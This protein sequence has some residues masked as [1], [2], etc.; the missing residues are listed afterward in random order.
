M[1]LEETYK[2]FVRNGALLND[3]KEQLKK[4]QY[5]ALKI[6]AILDKMF[7]QRPINIIKHLTNKEDLAGIPEAIL[8]AIWRRRKERNLEGYVIT[9]QFPSLLPILTYAKRELRKELAIGNGKIFDGGEFDNQN[10][11]KELVKLRQE[12]SQ[13]LGYKSLVDYVLEERM[14][15][16]PQKVL[17]FEQNYW[18]KQNLCRKDGKNFPF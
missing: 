2:G 18:L 3:E 11:I 4:Y 13:L 15:K 8:C 17:N 9:L 16:S 10:L 7:W 12:K 5:W 1:L 6:F 14:A